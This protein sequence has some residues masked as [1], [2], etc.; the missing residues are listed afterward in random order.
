MVAVAVAANAIIQDRQD[1]AVRVA[2]VLVDSRRVVRMAGL[3]PV[4]EEVDLEKGQ[5][6]W[7]A[8]VAQEL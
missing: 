8:T 5:I 6:D 1:Q 3:I 7:V 4:A 2:A